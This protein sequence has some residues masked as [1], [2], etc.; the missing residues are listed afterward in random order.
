MV[1]RALSPAVLAAVCV[2]LL[3]RQG[4]IDRAAD[5]I[6]AA[7][8]RWM[9][10]AGPL[11]LLGLEAHGLRWWLLVRR[12]R[13]VPVR[14]V[15][16]TLYAAGAAGVVLPLRAGAVVQVQVLHGRYGIGRAA[17][18]GTLAAE[19]IIDAIVLPLLAVPV[20]IALGWGPVAVAS[21]LLVGA[22]AAVVLAAVLLLEG[23]N[24]GAH[25][26]AARVPARLR[27]FGADLHR[28]FAG[29]RDARSLTW[30]LLL[31]AG[32]WLISAVAYGVM[33]YAFG[34]DVSPTAFLAVEVMANL[35]GAV[36]LTQGNVGSYELA[37]SGTLVAFGARPEEA[38]AF[39]VA[40]HAAIV[41]GTMLL[42][43]TS[44]IALRLGRDDLLGRRAP[45]SLPLEARAA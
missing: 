30:L 13:P 4:A 25:P 2:A 3:L 8:W 27:A 45:A 34:L 15:L 31:T 9:L 19:A 29:M 28:G 23:R 7:G 38:A 26:L 20:V 32:T 17:L 10:I 35:S 37:V 41:A 44:A 43:V 24:P 14:T 5:A 42:G 12:A 6:R 22:L 33:G 36:A 16:H 21:L 18:A 1:L 39:A 40:A 11:A